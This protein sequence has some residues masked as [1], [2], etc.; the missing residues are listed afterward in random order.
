MVFGEAGNDVLNGGR[1]ADTLDGGAGDDRLNGGAGNDV[2]TGGGG[3]DVFQ[4]R[5]A[6]GVE[7]ITDFDAT[8][9]LD[10]GQGINGL[11]EITR[12]S[13]REHATLTEDGAWI[14]LGNGNGVRLLGLDA[15]GLVELIDTQLGFI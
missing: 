13:V 1:G 5:G 11:G 8:D 15:V 4:I 6:Y 9:R 3:A 7:T 14:D 10:I 12:D 2:L